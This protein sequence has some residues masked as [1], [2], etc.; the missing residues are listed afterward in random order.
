MTVMTRQQEE[1]LN[2]LIELAGDPA[3][4]EEALRTA[5]AGSNDPP[6]IRE[7]VRAILEIKARVA[8][9]ADAP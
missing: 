1:L 9:G 6:T 3:V 5:A 4:V 2:R 8:A 7:V